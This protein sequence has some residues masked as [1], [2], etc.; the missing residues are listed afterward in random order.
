MNWI[1]SFNFVRELI[2]KGAD[3]VAGFLVLSLRSLLCTRSFPGGLVG[4][5]RAR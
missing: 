1:E 2:H 3:A 5:S 4:G